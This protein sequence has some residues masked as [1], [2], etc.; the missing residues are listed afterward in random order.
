MVPQEK[1]PFNC[2]FAIVITQCVCVVI[3]LISLICIKYFFKG[4]YKQL[5]VF[6]EKE[7][8]SDTDIN[9]VLSDNEI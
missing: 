4:T 3:L 6:Y 1:K 5:K 8:C 2:Y 9:E 7:I